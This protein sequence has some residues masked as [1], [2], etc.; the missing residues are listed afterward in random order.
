M[1]HPR[2]LHELSRKL[3]YLQNQPEF[4][5]DQSA[6]LDDEFEELFQQ[7]HTGNA[8]ANVMQQS[9]CS[10]QLLPSRM[11]SSCADD[12][13]PRSE[14]DYNFGGYTQFS[15]LCWPSPRHRIYD[16]QVTTGISSPLALPSD[17]QRASFQENQR[18][19]DNSK[20][21]RAHVDTSS[22]PGKPQHSQ[23]RA[24][25][26][27]HVEK[28]TNYPER[29]KSPVGL[30]HSQ[31]TL[32][33]PC[34]QTFWNRRLTPPSI[35]HDEANE[36][37]PERACERQQSQQRKQLSNASSNKVLPPSKV[38][39][40]TTRRQQKPHVSSAHAKKV[41]ART[42]ETI[43]VKSVPSRTQVSSTVRPSFSSGNSGVYA[44]GRRAHQ[45]Q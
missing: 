26:F 22:P 14:L 38:T 39:S 44:G 43:T 21:K 29:R 28:L 40:K 13:P 35:A 33:F 1:A 9:C 19:R 23:F 6:P 17:R 41:V 27:K 34:Q 45:I 10:S 7:P 12:M 11:S 25:G 30:N 18:R 4:H 15:Q 20:P 36:R 24:S 31:P 42:Q 3:W 5:Y 8:S 37:S 32:R 16:S 2:N